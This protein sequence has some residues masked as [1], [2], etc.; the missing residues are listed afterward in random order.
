MS[1]YLSEQRR[2]PV[3]GVTGHRIRPARSRVAGGLKLGHDNATRL[4]PSV[5]DARAKGKRHSH[6]NVPLESVAVSGK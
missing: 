3:A 6:V 1:P 4:A 2:L 5:V